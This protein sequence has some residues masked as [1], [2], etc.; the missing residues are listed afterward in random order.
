[1][2]PTVLP[3]PS[4][5][6]LVI[7]S[8][9][10]PAPPTQSPGEAR[11]ENL[12]SRHEDCGL[13]TRTTM[14]FMWSN[15]SGWRNDVNSSRSDVWSPFT[16]AAWNRLSSRGSI[17]RKL[18]WSVSSSNSSGLAAG[19]ESKWMMLVV[20]NRIYS[21]LAKRASVGLGLQERERGKLRRIWTF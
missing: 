4:E 17:F 5:L 18:N 16:S 6:H 15:S 8:R 3:P 19:T 11:G 14:S 7:G 20:D 9:S 13:L 21:Y 2:S 10:R 1:M 12:S